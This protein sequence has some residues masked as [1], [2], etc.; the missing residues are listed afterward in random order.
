MDI[1]NLIDRLEDMVTTAKK[2]PFG[3][4]VIINE[5]RIFE[6]VDE[7]RASLPDELKEARW[8]VKEKNEI[9]AEA[10]KEANAIID[11]AKRRALDM[12]SETEIVKLSEAQASEIITSAKEKEREIRL[13]AEDYADEMLANLEVNLGKLLSAVQRGRDR[14]QGKTQPRI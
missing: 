3:A 4:G 9:L 12:T 2:V 11:D 5:Q 13:G 8:I 6:F 1:S 14:L 7:M 10:E